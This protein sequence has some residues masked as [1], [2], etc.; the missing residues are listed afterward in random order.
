LQLQSAMVVV[1]TSNDMSYMLPPVC[2]LHG[3]NEAMFALG[4]RRCDSAPKNSTS[5][6]FLWLVSQKAFPV[7]PISPA[8]AKPIHQV[9]AGNAMFKPVMSY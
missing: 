8:D 4:A 5:T 6:F 9:P 7:L 2:V 1:V 3:V